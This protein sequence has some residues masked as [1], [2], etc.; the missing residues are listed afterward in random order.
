MRAA[1][2]IDGKRERET[3]KEEAS[4]KKIS[5]LISIYIYN[6]A[7]KKMLITLNFKQTQLPSL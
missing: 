6:R 3:R 4:L 1:K 5:N 2:N 7:P